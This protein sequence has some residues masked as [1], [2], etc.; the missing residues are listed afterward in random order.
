MA[1]PNEIARDITIAIINKVGTGDPT[2]LAAK[3]SEV[4]T[5]IYKAVSSSKSSIKDQE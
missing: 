3:A 4:Y 5:T 2:Y 1:A